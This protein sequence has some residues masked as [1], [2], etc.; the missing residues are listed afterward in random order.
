MSWPWSQLGLSGPCG[1]SEVRRA[2]AERLKTAHPEEDPEGFQRLHAAYQAASGIARQRERQARARPAPPPK[3]ASEAAAPPR[4]EEQDLD[5]DELLRGEDPPRRAPRKEEEQDFDFDE[6]LRE[7]DPPRRAPRKE[8]EQ[9]F[10]FDEL[11]RGEDP[12]RCAPQKEEERDFDFDRLFAEGEAERAEARRRRGEERRQAQERARERERQVR[13]EHR[14]AYEEERRDRFDREQVRWQ[15]TEAILHTAEM[16]Y[17][18]QAEGEAWRNFFQSP[19]FQQMK[20]GLDLIFGL[21]DFISGHPDLSQEARLAL[22]LA[23]GFDKGVSQ[24]ELRTMYQMLQPAWKTEKEQKRRAH[25]DILWG[26]LIG[27]VFLAAG[28]TILIS[29]L[30]PIFAILGILAF[31]GLKRGWIG[32]G[33]KVLKEERKIDIGLVATV[34]CLAVGAVMIFTA[35]P[36]KDGSGGSQAPAPGEAD[37]RQQICIY[38]EEDF[39]REFH[40]YYD[41]DLSNHRFSNVFAPADDPGKMFLAGPDGE[42]DLEAGKRGYT[43]NYSSMM[44]LWALEGFAK[45]RGSERVDQ[46]DRD[47]EAWDT[48]GI[49]LIQLPF[50]GAGETITELGALLEELSQADWYQLQPPDFKVVLCSRE[51]EEGR[52][53]LQEHESSE[54]RFDAEAVRALYEKEFAHAYCAQIIRECEL[55]RDFTDFDATERYT[56]AD[57]GMAELKGMECCRILGLDGEGRTGMEYYI[58]VEKDRV[59]TIYCVPGGFWGSGGSEEQLEDRL[60]RNRKKGL[61]TVMVQYPCGPETWGRHR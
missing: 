37:P 31:Q 34:L 35:G 44:V 59:S 54:G 49:Y 15:S 39:G 33:P 21:E 25:R 22:F 14:R 46:M 40:S 56:L 48:A 17:S 11:L 32:R 53:I 4:K 13:Q 16:M 7:E 38:M 10:D 52:L 23:Y 51:L 6:L 2:Y 28:V 61:G 8:E 58:S 36:R 3:P 1:L 27:L 55:D 12:P 9:D 41:G 24:P 30:L 47:L 60:I 18:A 42:R 5:F 19:L 26:A 29:P 45:E 43:T 20:S 50:Y 57:G